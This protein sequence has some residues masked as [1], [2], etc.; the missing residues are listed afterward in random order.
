MFE[1]KIRESRQKKVAMTSRSKE[2][3]L[4]ALEYLYTDA[5]TLHNRNEVVVELY[6]VADMYQIEGLML[7]YIATLEKVLSVE[8]VVEVI[9]GAESYGRTC[10][11]LITV[12]LNAVEP[13]KLREEVRIRSNLFADSL[14]T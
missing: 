3:F 10:E 1:S 5:F 14:F 4:L 13:Y 11:R 12:C 8:N 2:L 6:H 7:L 9:Q